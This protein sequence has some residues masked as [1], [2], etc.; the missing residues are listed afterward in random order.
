MKKV[1]FRKLLIDYMSF[2]I[3]GLLCTGIVIWV[4]QAVN[5]L[6]IMIEDGRDYIVYIKFSLLNFPKILSKIF[7]FVLFFSLFYVTTKYELNNELIIFWNFGVHKMQVI[8]FIFKISIILL[9]FQLLLTLFV[10]PKTQDLARSFLRTSTV[11]FFGNFIKSQKF[12]DTIKG[13]TIYS[14]RKD[15][16]GNLFNLYLKK[17]IDNNQFQITY[18]K[19]GTFEQ[20]GNNPILVLYEGATIT[21]NNNQITNISFSKSDFSLSNLETN[22]ITYKKTQEMSSINLINCIKD[23]YKLE[24][25]KFK[26]KVENIENCSLQNIKNIFKELYKRFIVPF[27]IPI[28]I[29]S[30][31]CLIIKSKENINFTKY[32]LI[33]FLIGFGFII[34]SETTLK[35][36]QN[37]FYLNLKIFILPIIFLITIYLSVYYLTQKNFKISKKL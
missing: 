37:T 14:D 2:L 8:N 24:K 25:N 26:L 5:Y 33:I 17:E 18:A 21:S 6:D 15:K 29:L 10:V 36:I 27:Y 11:N 16:E 31:L 7:P 20:R 4:F 12:N 1:L 3:L 30:S 19:K 28:L 35:Y 13:V 23:F 34:F 9:L 22:T 32:R